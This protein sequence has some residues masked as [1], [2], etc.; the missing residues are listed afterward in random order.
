MKI[1]N[2]IIE[3]NKIRLDDST[4]KMIECDCIFIC[5]DV[6]RPLTFNKMAYSPLIDSLREKI[7]STGLTCQSIA[8]PYS[9]L[10]GKKAY[11]NPIS[12]NGS[13]FF[14]LLKRKCFNRII[15]KDPVIELFKKIFFK[16]KNKIVITIGINDE[17]AIA[18]KELNIYSIE[19]L[20]G[21]GY[22]NVPWD[23]NKK[24][25]K[26]LPSLILSMDPISTKTFSSLPFEIGV[27][28][29]PHPFLV[30]FYNNSIPSEWNVNKKKDYKKEILI[31]LQWG[32][33][34]IDSVDDCKNILSNGLYY[35]EI[36][37][38]VK[39]TENEIFWRF[40]FHPVQLRNKKKYKKQFTLINN[41]IKKYKNTDWIESSYMPLPALLMH[42]DGFITMHSM[43]CYEA[44]YF[45]VKTLALSPLLRDNG[46][47][48]DLFTDLE[49]LGYLIKHKND[50]NFIYNW[51]INVNKINANGIN[52]N[53]EDLEIFI[54]W[55]KK[56]LL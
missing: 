8:L 6:D 14:S 43:A 13:Y 52:S 3:L 41:L 18:A 30:K 36:E 45:G 32:Y 7:E 47:Y 28:E 9:K 1:R 46:K 10:T 55:F 22:Q 29:I 24:E 44:S 56:S 27:K 11:K 42:C 19:L 15:K 21:I 25:S 23:W 4:E 26:C 49:S 37:K 54:D 50:Y 12:I 48:K 20:H 38:I 40:R 34:I 31:G 51:I 53:M 5:H 35:S 16:C 2:A 17:I 39:N 33:D